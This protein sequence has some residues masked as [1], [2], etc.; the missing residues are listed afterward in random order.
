MSYVLREWTTKIEA[1]SDAD[2]IDIQFFLED[3]GHYSSTDNSWCSDYFDYLGT[4][5]VGPIRV[6]G[7]GSCSVDELDT[8][9]LT[10]FGGT[11]ATRIWRESFIQLGNSLWP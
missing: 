3:L 4:L 10:L 2:I 8:V 9:I 7:A 5:N 6:F 11:I 1:S